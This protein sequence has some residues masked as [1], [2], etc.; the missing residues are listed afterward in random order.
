IDFCPHCG[1]GLHDKCTNC[2][3]RKST[4]SKYCHACG[5]GARL[6]DSKEAAAQA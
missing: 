3:V 4:F 1:I 5:T 2:G 6:P